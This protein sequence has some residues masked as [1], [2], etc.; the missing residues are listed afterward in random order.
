[1]SHP[2]LFRPALV[3]GYALDRSPA[4]APAWRPLEPAKRALRSLN[5]WMSSG[6]RPERHYM[7]GGRTLGAKSLSA[8]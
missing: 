5:V 1:M 7:R 8:R 6:Y 2:A 3:S 4:F